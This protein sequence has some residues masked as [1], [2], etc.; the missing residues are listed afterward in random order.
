MQNKENQRDLEWYFNQQ[1]EVQLSLF[2]HYIEM[3][4]IMANNLL[5]EEL[6]EKTG[7]RYQ[8]ERP[9]SG[10]YSRWG[11]NPGSIRIGEEKVPVRVPRI[12]DKDTNRTLSPEIY[13]RLKAELPSQEVM[14]KV[15]LGISQKDYEEVVKQGAESF[16]LSQSSISRAFIEETGKALEEFENRDLR[17]Y[18]FLALVIDGKYLAKDA[19]V[20]ALGITI[21]GVKLPIGII[22]SSSENKEAIK[23]LLDNLISRNFRY[24][25]GIL[26]IVDGSKALSSAVKEV[27]EGFVVIQR[28]QWH[29]RENVISYLN[30]RQA[31]YY[32]TRLQVAYDKPDYHSA[33]TEL[34]NV[35]NELERINHSAAK[36]LREGM[37]ETLTI[38]RLGFAEMGSSFRTTNTLENINHLIM[39]HIGKVKNWRSSY[40]KMRWMAAALLQVEKKLRR[41][42]NYYK[43]DLLRTGIKSELKL[44]REMIA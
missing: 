7:E 16:G 17:Y 9:E 34:L 11:S 43:L 2:S 8:R 22:Q 4:K 13:E 24:D 25:Q 28:C 41:V 44:K 36:S 30:E 19:M 33:R 3:M 23:G 37:E 27:F 1:T 40:M 6:K 42:D 14:K 29:K 39:K 20:I 35:L 18:D 10:R 32:R 26:A 38:H 21:T 31:D 15:I 5:Q 12:Y